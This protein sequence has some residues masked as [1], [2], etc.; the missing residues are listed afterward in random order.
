MIL[1]TITITT[2]KT[3][4]ILMSLIL[5]MWGLTCLADSPLT[6]CDIHQAYADHPIVKQALEEQS[7]TPTILNFLAD[8]NRPVTERAAVVSALGWSI[9]S[10]PY[11]KEL[12]EYLCKKY[13]AK[14]ENEF[15]KKLDAGTLV[16]YAYEKALSNYFQ[17]DEAMEMAKQA[18][19]KDKTHSFSIN[20][21]AALIAAQHYL[22]SDWAMVYNVVNDVV[23]DGSLNLDMKQEAFEIIWDYIK[24]YEKY[25]KNA[26][27]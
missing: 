7:M 10:T 26:P 25:A 5:V 15:F 11:A 6:S 8:N 3:T 20:M 1:L 9:D 18:V 24:L 17:V 19:K 27:Q 23:M 16:I 13:K 12:C 14:G 2:M 22:D 21:I 4:R